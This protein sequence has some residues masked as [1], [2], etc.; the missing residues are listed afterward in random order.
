M[1]PRRSVRNAEKCGLPMTS[2]ANSRISSTRPGRSAD[3]WKS[4]PCSYRQPDVHGP[5]PQRSKP[6]QWSRSTCSAQSGTQPG[7]QIFNMSLRSR[8]RRSPQGGSTR[9][10]R[11]PKPVGFRGGLRQICSQIALWPPLAAAAR[12]PLLIC[13]SQTRTGSRRG[14]AGGPGAPYSARWASKGE[15]LRVLGG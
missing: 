7:G 11:L 3:R 15:P 14:S 10:N 2:L 6:R 9:L 12:L 1:C 4:W 13:I 8:S 5:P